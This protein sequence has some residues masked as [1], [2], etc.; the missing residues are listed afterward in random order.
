[1]CNKSAGDAE[2]G[3][4]S[5]YSRILSGGYLLYAGSYGATYFYVNASTAM[6][7][8]STGLGIGTTSPLAPLD[9]NGNIYSSGNVLVDNIY[10]RIQHQVLLL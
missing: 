2:F 7:L 8:N 4:Q 6:T 1:M 5:G 9:V 3:T 10:S